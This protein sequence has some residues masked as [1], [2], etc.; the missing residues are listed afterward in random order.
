[1]STRPHHQPLGRQLSGTARA[2]SRAFDAALAG[3]GGSLPTWS[4]LL[5]LKS[6][7]GASQREIAAGVGIQGATLTH[8]LNAMESAGLLTRRRD[9]ANRRVHVVELTETG[10]EAFLRM[11]TAAGGFDRRLH[12]GLD[13]DDT[14]QLS[15]LLTRLRA[16]VDDGAADTSHDGLHPDEVAVATPTDDSRHSGR[17][18]PVG[19]G[20]RRIG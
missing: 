5:T 19:P 10:E 8:H 2:V 12:T 18:P 7:P 1:M 14:A 16:N 13:A 11:R 6:N 20:M 17:R 3:V 4:V 15:R 9:P